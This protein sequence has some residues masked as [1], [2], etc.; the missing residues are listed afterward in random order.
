MEFIRMTGIIY[1]GSQFTIKMTES[2]L[3]TLNMN[4]FGL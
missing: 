3:I 4:C 2:P 1:D